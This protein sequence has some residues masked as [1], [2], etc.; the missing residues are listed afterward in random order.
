MPSGLYRRLIEMAEFETVEAFALKGRVGKIL[1]RV[2]ITV[3]TW[4]LLADA[5]AACVAIGNSRPIGN[6][7]H[8]ASSAEPHSIVLETLLFIPY[9]IS[10]FCL[11]YLY[12]V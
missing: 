8:A 2:V 1:T 5:E 10:P 4:H 6:F 7:W 12:V 11:F 3:G 9:C